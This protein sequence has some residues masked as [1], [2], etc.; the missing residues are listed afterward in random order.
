MLPPHEHRTL[1][2]T[3]Y[4]AEDL[5]AAGEVLNGWHCRLGGV[6]RAEEA[7]EFGEPWAE[8]LIGA[9]RAALD[10]Y[11]EQHGIRPE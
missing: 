7:R 9:Y 2:L 6:E 1:T 10:R 3:V 8:H 4:E 11:A 5:A